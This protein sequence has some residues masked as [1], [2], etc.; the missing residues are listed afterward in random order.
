MKW[1]ALRATSVDLSIDGAKF[2]SYG[3]GAQDHLEYFACD[4]KSHTYVLT[5][6]TGSATATATLIVTSTRT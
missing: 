3:G 1:T 6:R 2:A 5:A 4:G